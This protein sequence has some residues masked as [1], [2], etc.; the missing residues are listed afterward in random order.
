MLQSTRVFPG[1][2][3]HS[4][5]K[6]TCGGKKAPKA[7]GNDDAQETSNSF[8]QQDYGAVDVVNYGGRLPDRRR[9]LV[10]TSSAAAIALGG[11]LF[12]LTS[13]LLG[14]DGGATARNLRLDV[15]F[16]IKGYKR[17]V[18]YQNGYEF[19]YPDFWLA[20]QRLYRRYAERIE[21]QKPLDL[22]PINSTSASPK[23]RGR[24]TKYDPVA[25]FGP[26][27]GTGE[28]NMSVIVAP[29]TQGFRV[30]DLG[31]PP[32]ASEKFLGT[33]IAPK[34]SDKV[35]ELVDSGSRTTAHGDL[36][37]WF[38]FTVEKVSG[39]KRWKRHNLA[40][41]GAKNDVLYTF[42]AQCSESRWPSLQ[43]QY[44]TAADSFDMLPTK[45]SLLNADFPESL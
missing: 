14:L 26:P 6:H 10:G 41:V 43:G 3:L 30:S 11:N 21:R 44:K 24:M 19:I 42:N 5:Q 7:N 37:Y 22:P 13:G 16:P 27:K 31:D 2:T 8:P 35:A 4:S 20:D 45:E 29:I 23:R 33:T 18:D 9:L 25:G 39:E 28:D 32:A 40:I 12:G 38:E 15:L 17:C 34:G 36:V 1:I